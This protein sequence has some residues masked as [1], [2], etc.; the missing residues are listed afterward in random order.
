MDWGGFVL[1]D[2][3]HTGG[4][5]GWVGGEDLCEK[6]CWV[7][8]SLGACVMCEC[9]REVV[10]VCDWCGIECGYG[11]VWGGECLGGSW[12]GVCEVV[13]VVL[14]SVGWSVG[15]CGCGLALSCVR[16]DEVLF[17]WRFALMYRWGTGRCLVV[18]VLADGVGGGAYRCGGE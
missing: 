4:R 17:W 6:G 7:G 16:C 13:G 14:V 11:M 9:V 3:F 15:V 10:V 2:E 5:E 12:V 18:V 8:R 1:V